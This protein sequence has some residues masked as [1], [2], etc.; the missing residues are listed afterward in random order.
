MDEM[1]VNKM[2]NE[3]AGLARTVMTQHAPSDASDGHLFVQIFKDIF[4]TLKL[5]EI[6]KKGT[7][8]KLPHVVVRGSQIA[9]GRR[10]VVD[11]GMDVLLVAAEKS[12]IDW[13]LHN[14]LIEVVPQK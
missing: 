14:L 11:E 8:S 13:N 7:D 10:R 3:A 9:S 4:H 6:T 1:T 12:N 5:L 2:V